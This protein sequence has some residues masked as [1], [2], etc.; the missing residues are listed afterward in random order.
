MQFDETTVCDEQGHFLIELPAIAASFDPFTL[1]V[2]AGTETKVLTDVLFGEV[3]IAGGQSNMQM[4][5]RAVQGGDQMASLA[6]LYLCPCA[7]TDRFRTGQT[8][9]NLWISPG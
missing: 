8:S 2:Q 6:N 3:W 5:L 7:E 1:T 4:P 9:E